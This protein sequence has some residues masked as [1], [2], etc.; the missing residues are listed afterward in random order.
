MSALLLAECLLYFEVYF[1]SISILCIPYF[2]SVKL[3]IIVFVPCP[4]LFLF[5]FKSLEFSW[6]ADLVLF[7]S[8]PPVAIVLHYRTHQQV[9]L[10]VVVN[11][12]QRTSC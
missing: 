9:Q 1:A 3:F 8:D 7:D 11:P 2:Y 5:I 6:Q 10:H 12:R 4:H